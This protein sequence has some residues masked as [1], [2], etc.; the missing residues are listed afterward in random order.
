[1]RAPYLVRYIV[2]T[3]ENKAHLNLRDWS[4]LDRQKRIVLTEDTVILNRPMGIRRDRT[5]IDHLP[6]SHSQLLVNA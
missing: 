3:V 1:M 6:G 4:T 2:I 5:H